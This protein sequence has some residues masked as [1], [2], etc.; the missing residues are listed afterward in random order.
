MNY[1][2]NLLIETIR[3]LPGISLKQAEKLAID[4]IENRDNKDPIEEIIDFSKKLIVD[5]ETKL[6]TE[7]DIDPNLNKNKETLVILDSNKDVSNFV[8]KTNSNFSMFVLG[9]K[10]KTDYQ[11]IELINELVNRLKRVSS[12]YKTKEILFFTSPSVESDIIIEVVKKEFE[13]N[14]EIKL[15]RLS[16]GIPFGGTIEY[17]DERTMKEA[18]K[19]RGKI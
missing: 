6:I 15:T 1:K 5:K 11:N 3:N 10:N 2:L 9:F 16:M 17:S 18:F 13:T 7:I 12:Q 4:I 14:K 8:N 19:N